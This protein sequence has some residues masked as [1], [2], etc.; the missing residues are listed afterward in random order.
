MPQE[1]GKLSYP[2]AFI[3]LEP[4]DIPKT[5]TDLMLFLARTEERGWEIKDVVVYP[6]YD[7]YKGK[8][9]P[10]YI[11][12]NVVRF[13]AETHKMET[14]RYYFHHAGGHIKAV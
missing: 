13:K 7:F 2:V 5:V 8:V 1:P 6:T 14:R 4:S 11:R 3:D 12:F 9:T 10:N